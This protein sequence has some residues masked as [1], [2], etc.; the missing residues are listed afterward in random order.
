MNNRFL[1][2]ILDASLVLNIFNSEENIYDT[3]CRLAIETFGTNLVW[4]GLVP[5][6]DPEFLPVSGDSIGEFTQ[7]QIQFSWGIL[8]DLED[9]TNLSFVSLEKTDAENLNYPDE[10]LLIM[11]QGSCWIIND[12]EAHGRHPAWRDVSL[13]FG[14]RS[15]VGIPLIGMRGDMLGVMHLFTKEKGFFTDQFIDALRIFANMTAS[16]IE[17]RRYVDSLDKQ[18]L[19]LETANRQISESAERYRILSQ[20]FNGLLDAIPD[21]L[22][23]L[24]R[25][26]K[27]LWANKASEEKCGKEMVKMVGRSC[28]EVWYQ[29]PSPCDPC[30]VIECF[31]SDVPNNQVVVRSDGRIWDIRTVPLFD[32]RHGVTKVIELKRD[33]TEHKKMEEQF[34][35]AQR[36]ESIGCLAG[37]VAHD[38]NNMLSVILGYAEL[39]LEKTDPDDDRYDDLKEI[40]KAGVRSANITRQLLAFARKQT[41]VPRVLDLNETIESML[42][43]FRRLIGEDINLTWQPGRN[44]QAIMSDPTQLD[45]ILANLCVNARD[46]I[47]GVGNIVIETSMTDLDADYC[48]RH[49]GAV[50]GKYVLIAFSDDGCGIEKEVLDRIF[51]PFFTTKEVGRGTGLGLATVY[52][53]VKQSGGYIDVFSEPGRGTAFKI[54]LPVYAA[55]A[56]TAEDE[57]ERGIQIQLGQGE[58]VLVVED[59]EAILR[60][61]RVT[62]EKQGYQVLTANTPNQAI[63]L[64]EKHPGA[65]DLLLTDMIMP[66]M[67]GRDLANQLVAIYPK[68]KC[69]FMSGYVLGDRSGINLLGEDD[70]FIQKP[71]MEKTLAAKL[72]EVLAG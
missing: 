30:P 29:L 5:N 16:A 40:L 44:L 59:E 69:L 61:C 36:M 67:N 12:I 1:K 25:E 64:A 18:V 70:H 49:V 62:L 20:E 38:Y 37:G 23:L 2:K 58:K 24:D 68:L 31:N 22:M 10:S 17:I 41:A 39:A 54:Y 34:F 72:R 35:H 52:G 9:P 47:I 32:E 53:I 48:A 13:Q 3:A 28:H 51:E 45:Q 60:L 21:S 63:A 7:Q 46:A 42:K 50:P 26:L 15:A 55:K 65:I 57:R 4:L 19:G 56:G 27:V 43:M 11:D 6:G 71:F 14:F 8:T 33:I 66:E